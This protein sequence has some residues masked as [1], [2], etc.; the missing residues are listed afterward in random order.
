MEETLFSYE[1]CDEIDSGTFQFLDCELL[2]PAGKYNNGDK[3][4]AICIDY[5][6]GTITFFK[7][8]EA[9]MQEDGAFKIKLEI[10]E[11]L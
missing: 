4:P 3:F 1:A 9:D 11:P 7:G 10:G 5:A 8:A 6:E 2:K